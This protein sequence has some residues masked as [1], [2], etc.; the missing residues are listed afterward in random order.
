MPPEGSGV[1][2]GWKGTGDVIGGG[3]GDGADD[4]EVSG[5]VGEGEGALMFGSDGVNR[6]GVE[7]A[8]TLASSE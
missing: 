8:A 6:S 1:G 3:E 4:G 5:V 7:V 2:V